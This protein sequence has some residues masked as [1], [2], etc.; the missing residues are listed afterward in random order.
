VPGKSPPSGLT[1]VL[2]LS[3]ISQGVKALGKA[4]QPIP[5]K[6]RRRG[7]GHA[8]I[9]PC[10]TPKLGWGSFRKRAPTESAARRRQLLISHHKGRPPSWVAEDVEFLVFARARRSLAGLVFCRSHTA[11]LP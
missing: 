8:T 10:V 2:P 3:L 7:L 1:P 5:D 9:L 6:R 11:S 4:S